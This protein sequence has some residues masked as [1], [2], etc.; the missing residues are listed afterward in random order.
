[1]IS[2][3]EE[4]SDARGEKLSW[5]RVAKTELP[6]SLAGQ[7]RL[8]L[9]FV[10]NL[11]LRA[12]QARLRIVEFCAIPQ[13]SGASVAGWVSWDCRV[14]DEL[15]QLLWHTRQV[16]CQVAD[17]SIPTPASLRVLAE[18]KNRRLAAW[19]TLR[20]KSFAENS[21]YEPVAGS[22]PSFGDRQTAGH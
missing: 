4:A 22:P 14:G 11:D 8:S 12:S 6:R 5:L 15:P 13:T 19:F 10:R 2:F 9:S 3:R 17:S 21:F 1:M 20:D 16:D 18:L 7:S